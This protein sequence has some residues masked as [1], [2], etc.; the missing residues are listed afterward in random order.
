[1]T[2]EVSRALARGETGV[3]DYLGR[4]F[5]RVLISTA[6]QHTAG[7]RMEAAHLLGLGRNTLTRKIQELEL[8]TR[9]DD[10]QE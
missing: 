4:D 8:D 6:L 10:E 5:E 3:I 2:Q 9:A 7:R 1:M